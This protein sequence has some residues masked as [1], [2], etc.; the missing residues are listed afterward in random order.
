M[1][2]TVNKDG[3]FLDDQKIRWVT[4]IDLQNINPDDGMEAVLHVLVTEA[5]VAWALPLNHPYS[6]VLTALRFE[7]HQVQTLWQK[8]LT[9]LLFCEP[10]KS[11]TLRIAVYRLLLTF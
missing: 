4:R 1:K 10:C 7:R 5:E 6:N 2:L 11:S 9:F 8:I 3:V